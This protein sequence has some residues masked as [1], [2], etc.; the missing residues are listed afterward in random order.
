MLLGVW[1]GPP[2]H[3]LT[4]IGHL[5]SR[6][7]SAQ[8]FQEPV[9]TLAPPRTGERTDVLLL[10]D[11]FSQANVWQSQ[12]T[13]MS[14][15]RIATWDISKVCDTGDW[16]DQA[17][18]GSLRA[19]ART[20][21]IQ[22][23]EREFVGRLGAR[24]V[25]RPD[26]PGRK[27][28]E[29]SRFS[30]LTMPKDV[31]GVPVRWYQIFPVDGDYLVKTAL[32]YPEAH[33]ASGRYA[34]S[35]VV[36]VDLLRSDLF[37]SRLSSRLAYYPDDEAKFSRWSDADAEV[38]VAR[39]AEWRARAASA[40][41]ALH[42]LAIPDKSSVYWP[43]IREE[44][45]FDYPN[46][47]ERLFALIGERLGSQYNLLPYLRQ[48]AVSQVDLY[49]PDDTHLSMAG[50]RLLAARVAQWMPPDSPTQQPVR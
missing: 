28:C 39:L 33:V 21:I 5:A 45:R 24:H 22:S 35:K 3:D 8:R 9:E 36:V 4:R 27:L 2:A 50:Y 16:V 18:A 47:G 37:S 6:D 15:L 1:L 48:Q 20:V 12:L 23:V 32:R 19:G 46:K 38:I 11:S 25:S 17:I 10:G 13:N 49:S 42:V 29:R 7:F 40:G 14:G 44:Q 41:I 34:S 26:K 43:Y 30:P 31:I